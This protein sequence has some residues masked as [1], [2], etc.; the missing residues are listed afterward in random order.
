MRNEDAFLRS[1]ETSFR[2]GPPDFRAANLD[3]VRPPPY[4][5][6]RR[7]IGGDSPDFLHRVSAMHDIRLIRETPEAFDAGLARRNLAPLSSQILALDAASRAVTTRLQEMQAR[8]NEAS[9]LIGQAKAK[10][11]EAAAAALMA[12]VAALKETMPVEEQNERDAQKAVHDALAAIPNLPAADVPPGK[13]EDDNVEVRRSGEP[14]QPN[15]AAKEHFDLGEALGQMDFEAAAKM[16]GARFV[17]LK[18]QLA[19]LERALANF[20]LDLH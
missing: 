10:K 3:P 9:K 14:R 13:D 20:M 16:S 17:V 12:E 2:P 11:D 19:R 5:S 8:R 6:A 7:R 18:G 4:S 15:F 1:L